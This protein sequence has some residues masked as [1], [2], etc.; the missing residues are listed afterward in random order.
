MK[1]ILV[2][3]LSGSGKTHF[4]RQLKNYLENNSKSVVWFNAD[5]IRKQYNDWDFSREGR[6]RQSI[7][8][9]DLSKNNVCDYVICDFIAPLPKMRDNFK[10]DYTVWMDTI[11]K[12]LYEDTNQMFIPPDKYDFRIT[13]KNA[14]KWIELV[15]QYIINDKEKK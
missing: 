13:E 12:C 5:L 14:E 10:A 15:G 7:R 4:S 6:L 8:M 2:M 1:K 3:G 9:F 11:D